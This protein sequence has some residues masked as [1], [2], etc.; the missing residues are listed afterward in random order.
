MC[1]KL[2][3]SADL[4]MDWQTTVELSL[5]HYF[6]WEERLMQLDLDGECKTPV[7]QNKTIK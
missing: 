7:L 3:Q 4:R 6:V 5:L 1:E 2:R